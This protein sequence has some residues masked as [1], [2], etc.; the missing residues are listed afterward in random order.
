LLVGLHSRGAVLQSAAEGAGRARVG[1]LNA[2][3]GSTP[4][5]QIHVNNRPPPTPRLHADQTNLTTLFKRAGIPG[6]VGSLEGVA[7]RREL[8]VCIEG[9]I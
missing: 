1:F 6:G 9:M 7:L 5:N 2:E 4:Q 8:C 3:I